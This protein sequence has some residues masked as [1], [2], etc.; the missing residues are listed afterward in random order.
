MDTGVHSR[1]IFGVQAFNKG[2]FRRPVFY[3]DEPTNND[4]SQHD[5]NVGTC[6]RAIQCSAALPVARKKYRATR[7]Q[8]SVVLAHVRSKIGRGAWCTRQ[9]GNNFCCSISWAREM[10]R[11]FEEPRLLTL[12][13]V[14]AVWDGG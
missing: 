6:S 8:P 1:V 13:P 12:L 10:W 11:D 9:L 3:V 7:K 14:G 5:G 2:H 4:D